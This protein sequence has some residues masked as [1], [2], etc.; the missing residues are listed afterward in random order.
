M[1]GICQKCGEAIINGFYCGCGVNQNAVGVFVSKGSRDRQTPISDSVAH[2]DS[3]ASGG[4]A[5]G[6]ERD[7][8][9]SPSPPDTLDDQ[10]RAEVASINVQVADLKAEVGR[11]Q[12][13]RIVTRLVNPNC[14]EV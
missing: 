4:D 1:T 3:P 9:T 10:A 2:E 11:C 7:P 14:Y 12:W 6:I 8:A 5:E 13:T